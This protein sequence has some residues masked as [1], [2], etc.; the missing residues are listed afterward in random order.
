MDRADIRGEARALLNDEGANPRFSDAKLNFRIG[1]VHKVVANTTKVL[2]SSMTNSLA[3]DVREYALPEGSEVLEVERVEVNDGVNTYP[4]ALISQDELDQANPYWKAT[5][6]RPLYY[7]LRG[8]NLGV[9]P[10]PGD[11]QNGQTVRAEYA[12]KATPLNDDS[13]SPNYPDQYHHLIIWGVVEWCKKED[14]DFEE[15]SMYNQ[16]FNSGLAKM[17]A[18]QDTRKGTVYVMRSGPAIGQVYDSIELG[19]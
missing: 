9:V 5:K 14:N 11:A 12:E 19:D 18:E 3:A 13:D 8:N 7:Y 6:G 1:E 16:M 17:K 15:A 4:L 2:K 10:L